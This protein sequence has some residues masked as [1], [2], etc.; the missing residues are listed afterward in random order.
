[1]RS[2]PEPHIEPEGILAG[3]DQPCRGHGDDVVPEMGGDCFPYRVPVALGVDAE[4]ESGGGCL[5]LAAAECFRRVMVNASSK[6]P[7]QFHVGA[8]EKDAYHGEDQK[9]GHQEDSQGLDHFVQRNL[10]SPSQDPSGGAN[11]ATQQ[12]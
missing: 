6:G 12:Q 1:M 9:T 11:H 7:D 2:E 10:A 8:A 3:I 4:S 5:S